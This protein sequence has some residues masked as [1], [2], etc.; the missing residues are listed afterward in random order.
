MRSFLFNVT[1]IAGVSTILFN[2]N[3]LLRYDGYYMLS[4]LLEIPNLGTR[5]NS[6]WGYLANRYLLGTKDLD[7]VESSPGERRWFL[8][9]GP[10]SFVYRFVVMMGIALF[11]ASEFFI[12]GVL[13]ALWSFISMIVFPIIKNLHYLLFNPKLNNNR[14]RA[15][16]ASS[17]L[18][19]GL[20]LFLLLVPMPLRTQ[21]E[22]VLW[23]PKQ[24]EIRAGSAGFVSRILIPVGTEV[25]PGEPLILTKDSVLEAEMAV[26]RARVQEINARRNAEWVKDR[27]KAEITRDELLQEQEKLARA[28]ERAGKLLIRSPARG[29]FVLA[30]E[31]D[32]PGRFLQQGELVGFVVDGSSN[33]VRVVVPQEDIDLVRRSVRDVAVRF[34]SHIDEVLPA[35]IIR[36]V[37][38]ARNELPSLALSTEGGG[39]YP[40]DPRDTNKTKTLTSLFQ[41]DLALSQ[42]NSFADD[43]SSRLIYGARVYVRFN[44]QP[45]PLAFQV[46]RRLRQ[47]FLSRLNV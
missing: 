31:K 43:V 10:A 27:V 15:I 36:E 3:P 9:Y 38:A 18:A 13:M 17:A 41:Y 28:E 5:A 32:L 46:W 26:S 8:F 35:T 23:L 44:H 14:W 39:R 16:V 1:M 24:A 29:H 19:G 6:Y 4:D 34:A 42:Q 40:I 30:N 2:G 7:P 20:A 37:P 11:L 45:E 12:V 33:L 47:L 22:G 25:D 21:S